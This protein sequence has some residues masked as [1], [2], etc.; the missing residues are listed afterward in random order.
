MT[1]AS[2]CENQIDAQ[3]INDAVALG[4]VAAIGRLLV[5]KDG[6]PMFC[7]GTLINS[8]EPT[9]DPSALGD[10]PRPY[11]LT[12]NSCVSTQE[13]ANSIEVT[14]FLQ[15][16]FCG[17]E[18]ID[19]RAATTFGGANLLATSVG[20]DA[21]L[22][23]L[24]SDPPGGVVYS[25]WRASP[26]TV[27]SDGH[28]LHH[29]RGD[30]MKI[31]AGTA[32][33]HESHNALVDAIRVEWQT[34]GGETGSEG[35]AFFV[36]GL[37]VGTLSESDEACELGTSHFGAFENFYLKIE[38]YLQ[39]DHG[40]DAENATAIGVPVSL[41]EYLTPGDSDY[42]QISMSEDGR[43]SVLSA[44]DID[45]VA[46]LSLDGEDI[47]EDDNSG[48]GENFLIERDLEPGDYILWIRGKSES[49]SGTYQL[50][51][52]LDLGTAPTSSP[53][54]VVAVPGAGLLEIS[55]DSV[56]ESDNGG[57][58]ITGYVALATNAQGRVAPAQPWLWIR[59]VRSGV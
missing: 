50:R 24:R 53:S 35:A 38:G 4:K 3:C 27:P 45:T 1:M 28:A 32:M 42:F 21:T 43:L 7:S 25:G 37:L 48:L 17:S 30:V 16:N 10:G 40:D 11:L 13:E 59:A 26:L 51:T 55:W 57:S 44:G 58:A 47:A 18:T 31:A 29:P 39:G 23:R 20:Q 19:H 46:T 8:N 14:W 12:S 54:N 36:D 56:P 49:T 22:L 33:S 5:E 41:E 52:S 6:G 9:S 34:G 15:H 2:G